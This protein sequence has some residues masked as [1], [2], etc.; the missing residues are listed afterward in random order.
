M[1]QGITARLLSFG[2][3]LGLQNS[4]VEAQELTINAVQLDNPYVSQQEAWLQPLTDPWLSTTVDWE[5]A[6]WRYGNVMDLAAQ[7][8]EEAD[9]LSNQGIFLK[10]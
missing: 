10:E 7:F 2:A 8:G 1:K 4:L 9:Y 6:E 3:A 5:T